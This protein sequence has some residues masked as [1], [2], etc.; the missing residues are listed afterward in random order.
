MKTGYSGASG[1]IFVPAN[2]GFGTVG[3]FTVS[4]NAAGDYYVAL[5]AA[6]NSPFYV[7]PISEGLRLTSFDIVYSIGT[8]ALTT[9]T[10]AV[11]STQYVAGNAAGTVRTLLAAAALPVVSTTNNIAVAN[12]PVSSP[13]FVGVHENVGASDNF[14]DSL[15]TIELAIVNPGTAVL[16]LYGAWL[17]GTREI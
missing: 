14:P 15:D 7:L 9:L 16:R 10:A 6:A 17:Y 4:R 3:T 12:V 1:G 11:Y 13:A 5:T 8:A 2:D